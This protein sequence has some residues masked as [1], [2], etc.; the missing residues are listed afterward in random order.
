MIIQVQLLKEKELLS[1]IGA[2]GFEDIRI[3]ES[4]FTFSASIR[5]WSHIKDVKWK[6]VKVI[7]FMVNK[8]GSRTVILSSTLTSGKGGG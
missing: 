3:G 7:S 4:V 8:K 1:V 6:G 2:L 5:Q